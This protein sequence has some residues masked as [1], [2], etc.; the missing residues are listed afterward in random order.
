MSAALRFLV[1]Q[2]RFWLAL[3]RPS[4]TTWPA[5]LALLVVCVAL[6][7]AMRYSVAR[8]TGVHTT[9]GSF[10]LAIVVCSWIGGW[11][12]G[13]AA[14][15]LCSLASAQ[16]LPPGD[17]LAIADPG[18]RF[19]W[20]VFV[21]VGGALCGIV[22]MARRSQRQAD[23]GFRT[24]ESL[25]QIAPVGIALFDK[26]MR[27][28]LVNR[29]LVE[30]NG[31][32][33]QAHLGR[34]VAEMFPDILPLV[35]A[36]FD[37]VLRMRRPSELF[38][39]VAEMPSRPGQRRFFVEAWFPVTGSED[40]AVGAIVMDV[41]A[42]RQAEQTLLDADARKDDFLATLSHEM[43][44][45]LAAVANGLTVLAMKKEWNQTAVDIAQRQIR[46]LIR[47]VDDLLDV[48]RI[49]TG[50]IAVVRE[51]VELR[52]LL[53][54]AM[55]QVVAAV[56]SK[57]QTI[58]FSTPSEPVH[59][60]GDAARLTQAFGNLL[61]N[62]SKFG[63]KGGT[64]TFH[65]RVEGGQV[66]VTVRDQGHGIPPETLPILFEMFGQGQTGPK[67][68]LRSGLGIGLALVK[69]IV[70]LHGGTIEVKPSV[71]GEGA[72]FEVR[73]PLAVG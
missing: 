37:N 31:I 61:H 63:P 47:L 41:T 6:A 15:V 21:V 54:A 51:R 46:I 44:N 4:A 57:A 25:I 30:I 60:D 59:L 2:S 12:L 3:R 8:W 53:S 16:L 73:L 62:A 18:H 22:E 29:A 43:R 38:E 19:E 14:L 28:R 7:T 42:Q 5:R 65:A 24:L 10:Y 20:M 11:R 1:S 39:V 48:S 49:R 52:P 35:Q 27:Y 58:D 56:Q 72:R 69:V 26:D 34:T 9:F 50:K 64:I 45:P 66:S 70:E 13:T 36:H 68:A 32:P 33:A 71:A 67:E 23:E 17:S 40:A 55:D